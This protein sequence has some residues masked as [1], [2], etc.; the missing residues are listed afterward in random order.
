[1]LGGVRLG[2]LAEGSHA[3]S[4]RVSGKAEAFEQLGATAGNELL[5][6]SYA[7]RARAYRDLAKD[8]A[9]WINSGLEAARG[10]GQKGGRP[11]ALNDQ[12]GNSTRI[13]G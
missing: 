3:N 6:A 10:R 5:R 7:D 8:R 2:S 11:R 13:V 1:V 12:H 4:C 9:D